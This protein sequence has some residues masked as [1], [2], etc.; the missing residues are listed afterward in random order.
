LL[1]RVSAFLSVLYILIV[2]NEFETN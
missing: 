1:E 2:I